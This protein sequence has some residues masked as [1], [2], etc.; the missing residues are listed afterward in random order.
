[1]CKE[2]IGS[3]NGGHTLSRVENGA[4]RIMNA[5]LTDSS[6]KYYAYNIKSVPE[7]W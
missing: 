3:K 4:R 5:I 7:Y 6:S 2:K 1:M